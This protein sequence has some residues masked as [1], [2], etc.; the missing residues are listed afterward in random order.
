MDAVHFDSC[1]SKTLLTY[2]FTREKLFLA[3]LMNRNTEGL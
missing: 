3:F 2:F 1:F